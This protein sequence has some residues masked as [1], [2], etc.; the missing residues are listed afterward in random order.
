MKIAVFVVFL[1]R[2]MLEK[3]EFDFVFREYYSPLYFFAC[4]YVDDE[5]ACRDIVSGAF[6]R[7][8]RNFS[9]VERESAKS[10]L[11]IAVRNLCVDYARQASR[12]REYARYVAAMSRYATDA[13]SLMEREELQQ[14]VNRSIDGLKPPTRDIFVACYVERKKYKEVAEQM[15]I[16]TATVKKHIV[17]ALK[18]VRQ[19]R[20]E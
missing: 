3:S 20:W 9:K 1:Q 19:R 2:N 11:Y 7:L 12:H 15:G 14:R 8:W 4:Q 16:S 6:E 18:A 10:F 5:E 13:S 17:K